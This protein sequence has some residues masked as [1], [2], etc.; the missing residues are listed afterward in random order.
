[1]TTLNMLN[2][3]QHPQC[4]NDNSRMSFLEQHGYTLLHPVGQ[5]SSIRRYFRVGKGAQTAILME[6]V[7]DN[8]PQATPGHSLAAFIAI[9]EWL[10]DI[11]AKA[12]AIYEIDADNGYALLEDLGQSCFKDALAN[13]CDPLALYTIAAKTLEHIAARDCPLD[14]PDYY[15]SHVHKRHRRVMDWFIPLARL[16]PNEEGLI[17][18]YKDAWSQI[19]SA[20]PPCPQGFVH[21]D[22]HAENLMHLPQGQGIKRCGI[23]DFQGA[24]IGPAPYDL[25]NLLED[26]RTDVPA[27]IRAAILKNK[28]ETFRV[29]YR[30][31]ATQFHCRVIGQFIKQAVSDGNPR[32]LKHM[33]RLKRYIRQGLRDPV[34]APLAAFFDDLG[35][36][37]HESVSE[38]ID[39]LKPLISDD[40][41]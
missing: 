15:D 20:L 9:A 12:P 10:N 18:A 26:A 11:G 5:D 29:W 25:A 6:T 31:L 8:S 35:I 13:G 32:Y 33:P 17:A 3:A 4:Y 30:V 40:A 36:S 14:L 7:P 22:F 28:D 16:R 19:E 27:E 38:R 21:V 39:T 1:M 41:Y 34:L 24:M 23:L 37:F 2:V